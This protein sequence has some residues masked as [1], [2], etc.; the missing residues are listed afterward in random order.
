V[1]DRV[2][3]SLEGGFTVPSGH[4]TRLRVPAIA[5][6]WDREETREGETVHLLVDVPGTP[7]GAAATLR[8]QEHDADGKHDFVEELRG[9][10]SGGKV[11]VPWVYRFVRDVDDAIQPGD[12]EK[13][14]HAPELFF[15]AKV[16]ARTDRSGI[17]RYKEDVAFVLA[18]PDGKPLAGRRFVITLA[19]GRKV[20][21]RTD[22]AGRARAT[23]VPPGPVR[24]EYPEG[25]WPQVLGR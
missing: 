16:G 20:E 9:T 24:I 19:D 17:L 18:G 1:S 6:R 13:G 14:F 10:V 2:V 21:G 12:E 5:A 23:G 22:E 11:D 8:I 4:L 25:W 7:D 15:D 3:D